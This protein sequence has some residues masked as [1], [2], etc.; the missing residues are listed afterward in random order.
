MESREGV[1]RY[2]T[3]A[4]KVYT[5]VLYARVDLIDAWLVEMPSLREELED[6]M[7]LSDLDLTS[8]INNR[9]VF[10]SS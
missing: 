4:D 7:H 5:N 9:L 8:T 1:D 2:G 10:H 6:E 3:R